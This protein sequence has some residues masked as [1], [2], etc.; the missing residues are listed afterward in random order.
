MPVASAHLKATIANGGTDSN[1][2]DMNGFSVVGI[3]IPTITNAAITPK[4]SADGTTFFPLKEKDGSTTLEIAASTGGFAVD[5]DFCARLSG[6][7]Y[8]KLVS[9]ASQGAERVITVIVAR[10]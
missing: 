8:L 4:V 10:A 3:I 2:I 9:G 5:A 6:Y 1:T 7:R